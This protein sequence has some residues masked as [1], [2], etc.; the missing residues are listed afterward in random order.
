MPEYD[1][2]T[3]HGR[4]RIDTDDRGVKRSDQSLSRFEKT[5]RQFRRQLRE[6]ERRLTSVED[7]LKQTARQFDKA[8]QSAK[9]SD[10]T[11]R[12]VARTVKDVDVNLLSMRRSLV[13][14]VNWLQ[15]AHDAAQNLIDP[16]RILG[17]ITLGLRR[18]TNTISGFGRAFTTWGAGLAAIRLLARRLSGI[19]AQIKQMPKWARNVYT[20]G[21]SFLALSSAGKFINRFV[22]ATT[23]LAGFYAFLRRETP[24]TAGA[25]DGLMRAFSKLPRGAVNFIGG[26]AL[27]RAGLAGLSKQFGF[28]AKVGPGVLAALA[29]GFALLSGVIELGGKTLTWFSNILLGVLDGAVQLSGALLALPGIFATMG[30]AGAVLVGIFKGLSDQFKDLASTDPE[31]VAKAFEALPDHLKPLGTVIKDLIPRLR[32]LQTV[33]QKS[34]FQGIETQL[35]PLVDTYLPLI[36]KGG[37]GVVQSLRRAKDELVGFVSSGQ[38]IS[39]VNRAFDLTSQTIE[40]LSKGIQPALQGL[41]DITIVGMEFVRDLTSGTEGLTQ[42][43]AEWAAV[44]RQNGN[45]LRWMQEGVQGAKDLASGLWDAVKAV[46]TI[47]TAFSDRSGDNALARFADSMERFNEAVQE[48]ARSG[49]LKELADGVRGLGTEKLEQL[50]DILTDIWDTLEDVIPVIRDFAETF[51]ETFRAGLAIALEILEQFFNLLDELGVGPYLGYIVGIAAAFKT[52]SVVLKPI[53]NL[54]K[55]LGGAFLAL[56]GARQTLQGLGGFLTFLTGGSTKAGKAVGKLGAAFSAMLGPIGAVAAAV[57]LLWSAFSDQNSDIANFNQKMEDAKKSVAEFGN[58]LQTAFLEDRGFA[59]RTVFDAVTK[60]TDESIASLKDRASDVPGIW[61]N[62]VASLQPGERS[63]ADEKSWGSP[64]D[65][66][67]WEARN[68]FAQTKEFNNMQKM[69]QDAEHAAKAFDHLGLSN[70]NLASA[71]TG[72]DAIFASLMEEIRKAPEGGAEASAT[73]QRMRDDFKRI[74]AEF[75][76]A[77]TGSVDLVNGIKAIADA[78]GDATTKLEGLKLALQGLGLLQTSAL[79][80]AFSYSEAIRE[81]VAGQEEFVDRSQPVND[82]LN[83]QGTSYNVMSVNA[84]NLRNALR[85]LAQNFLDVASNGGDVRAEWEKMQPALAELSR[86]FELPIEKVR[87]LAALEGAVPDVVSILVN[88]KGGDK[89]GQQ[90]AAIVAE[91]RVQAAGTEVVI[92]LNPEVDPSAVQK[93]LDAAL[94]A[95]SA[96]VNETTITLKPGVDPKALADLQAKLSQNGI[97]LPGSPPPAPVPVPV[98]PE[99][100]PATGATGTGDPLTDMVLGQGGTPTPIKVPAPQIDQ[101]GIDKIKGQIDE[102]FA[103]IEELK[104]NSGDQKIAIDVQVNGF[105]QAKGALDQLSVL[106][107]QSVAAWNSYQ[108][109]VGTVIRNILVGLQSLVSQAQAQ[110]DALAAGQY[111]RGAAFARDFAQ[112]ITDNIGAIVSAAEQAAQ[113]ARDRMPGSPA[114]KGPLSGKGWSGHSGAAFAED[115]AEGIVTATPQATAA[116]NSLAGGVGSAVQGPYDFGKFLGRL[117]QLVDFGSHIVEIIGQVADTVFSSLKFISDQMSGGDSNRVFGQHPGF[118]RSVSDADL[119]K[120]RDDELQSKLASAVESGAKQGASEG[121]S[122]GL[123]GVTRASGGNIVETLSEIG[124]EFG[125]EAVSTIRNEP[126]SYHH[127]GQAVDFG[128]TQEQMAAFANFIA[129]NFKDITNELIFQGKGFDPANLIGDK[130]FVGGTG[131]YSPG[132]LGQHRDHVHW[133]TEVAPILSD[134]IG[135]DVQRYLDDPNRPE[136]GVGVGAG[137]DLSELN[138]EELD[139]LNTTQGLSLKTEQGILDELRQSN[140]V[141][142]QAIRTGEDPNSSDDQVIQSLSTIQQSIDQ[143]GLQDTAAG[144]QQVQAL[145]GVKSSIMSQRGITEAGNPIDTASQIAASATSI[146]K[147]VFGVLNSGI[148]ALGGAK[149]LG[150]ILVRGVSNSEDIYNMVDEIQKFI[151]LAAR[152]AGAVSSISGAVGSI[153]SA[154][155]GADPSGGASGAAAAIQGVSAIAGLISGALDTVNGII[156]LTQEAYRIVGSYLGELFGY[157]AGAGLGQLEGDVRFLLDQNDGT[158]KAYSRDNPLDKRIHDLPGRAPEAQQPQI[159]SVTVYGGPGTD[160]RDTTRQMMWAVR[161]ASMGAGALN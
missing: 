33:F 122:D 58:E 77:G 160:P 54:V 59:G 144:R 108:N 63:S 14:A 136:H 124:K 150:D 34:F 79:D 12:R 75:E 105:E 129:E 8:D 131:Y 148:N 16:L 64:F 88:V 9:R 96:V 65:A 31:E 157:V 111:D 27:M 161:T 100:Q 104:A 123:S 36:E 110:F 17:G 20:L 28:L 73:L 120:Q 45:L 109:S 132:T 43:F 47:L 137:P 156:D 46:W 5:V 125:L 25:V 84:Q 40:N 107:S 70:E 13:E 134:A 103:K 44:N 152:I 106:L 38:T 93:A 19:D 60:Q 61:D 151:D 121:T 23:P 78:G 113:A 95:G 10:S 7:Q 128:G 115:F 69:A 135:A 56:R 35:Q 85:D 62:I 24:K 51:G 153:V 154:A 53:I 87:E 159:G 57:L 90:L 102:I 2:G 143:Q 140:S 4:I 82:I 49:F 3:A 29:G 42:R 89:V 72:S 130:E 18:G 39:D 80:A 149:A 114:K 22:R 15:R 142:D 67:F 91:A 98:Q 97:A 112:G 99:V 1:L 139:R 116:A 32:D 147:D 30:I 92:P 101:A 118:V 11:F 6:F 158:L 26:T 133:A 55:T 138:P 76:R 126:G 71:V 68:P 41:R 81:I 146:A 94:G 83:E 117:Q 52:I 141:L 21:S 50:K 119:Q 127:T 74:Q 155:G 86:Q 37:L 66:D 145:E 48:S